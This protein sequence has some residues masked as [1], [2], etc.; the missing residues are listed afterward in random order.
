MKKVLLALSLGICLLFA[1]SVIAAT[2]QSVLDLPETSLSAQLV[3]VQ[4]KGKLYA[5]TPVNGIFQVYTSK[6]GTT[7]ANTTDTFGGSSHFI[8]EMKSLGPTFNWKGRKKTFVAFQNQEGIAEIWQVK[9]QWTQSGID[10][11]TGD[12]GNTNV[13][14]LRALGSPQQL[15]AFTQHAEGVGVFTS[16]YGDSWEQV[17]EYGVG[18][19]ATAVTGVVQQSDQGSHFIYIGT[20]TGKVYRAQFPS[21]DTWTEV[22]DLGDEVTTIATHK[23]SIYIGV[24]DGGVTKV[25]VSTDAGWTSFEQL[26]EDSFGNTRNEEVT[27]LQSIPQDGELFA[28]VKN[29]A[30]GAQIVR[31]NEIS[32]TWEMFGENGLGNANNVQLDRIAVLRGKRYVGTIPATTKAEVY[33]WGE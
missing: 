19:D 4:V 13:T 10:G 21:L 14:A 20:D 26:G 15:F 22:A 12:S 31:L 32:N 25:L 2:F 8:K 16:A 30:E 11:L 9:R 23:E 24:N 28:L 33:R 3:K 1:Q 18:I 27:R 6:N 17:G 29:T 7:W 5:F